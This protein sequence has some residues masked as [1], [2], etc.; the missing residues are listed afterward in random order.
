V[1]VVDYRRLAK[2]LEAEV[3]LQEGLVEFFKGQCTKP[4][5]C[6]ACLHLTGDVDETYPNS[7]EGRAFI[8]CGCE[9]A[10]CF[11]LEV[12]LEGFG[13]NYFDERPKEVEAGSG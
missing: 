11:E 9:D 3:K 5:E 10:P 13:C 4:E 1:H 8:I 2:S 12:P 6:G 7:G